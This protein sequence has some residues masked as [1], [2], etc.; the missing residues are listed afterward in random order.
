MRFKETDRRTNF[1]QYYSTIEYLY[2]GV[3]RV[4]TMVN[5]HRLFVLNISIIVLSKY[6]LK[7]RNTHSNLC[8]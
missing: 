7:Q 4:N 3:C 2:F 1:M 8:V 6:Y 5:I